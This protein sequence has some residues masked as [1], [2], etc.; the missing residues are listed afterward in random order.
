MEGETTLPILEGAQESETDQQREAREARNKEVMRVYEHAEE[1][2]KFGVMR[3]YEAG[4][5]V[6]SVL[7]LA[8]GAEEKKFSPKT[9]KGKSPRNLVQ[10]ILRTAGIGFYQTNYYNV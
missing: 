5:K 9:S 4:K 3:R 7:Y 8:L 10:R 6:R 1:K 2:R